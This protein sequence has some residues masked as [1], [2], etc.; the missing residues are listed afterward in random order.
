MKPKDL[1]TYLEN[2]TPERVDEM[3]EVKPAE[4]YGLAIDVSNM[5]NQLGATQLGGMNQQLSQ[6]ANMQNMG[7]QQARTIYVDHGM[8]F[9]RKGTLPW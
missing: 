3:L 2:G 6:L 8:T 7:M 5:L 9:P 1:L 4:R